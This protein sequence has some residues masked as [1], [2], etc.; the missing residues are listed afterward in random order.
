VEGSALDERTDAMTS[1]V[2]QTVGDDMRRALRNVEEQITQLPRRTAGGE[3][4]TTL[5]ALRDLSA[6][7]GLT[8][9]KHQP[10]LIPLMETQGQTTSTISQLPDRAQGFRSGNAR[11]AS[12]VPHEPCALSGFVL[13]AQKENCHGNTRGKKEGTVRTK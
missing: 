11:T 12:C 1:S 4:L 5:S 7:K 13:R 10:N 3:G 8:G 6:K 2:W 9:G